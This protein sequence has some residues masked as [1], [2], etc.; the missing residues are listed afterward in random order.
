MRRLDPPGKTGGGI[1]VPTRP[2]NCCR[3]ADAIREHDYVPGAG[4]SP[5]RR[6]R[7]SESSW[8]PPPAALSIDRRLVLGLRDEPGAALIARVDPQ[9]VKRD[10]QPGPDADKEIDMGDAP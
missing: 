2:R 3:K 8:M 10:A 9:P 1:I 7:E 6:K 4:V 5:N